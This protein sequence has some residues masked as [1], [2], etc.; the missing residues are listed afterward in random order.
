M[1]AHISFTRG[2][3]P[4]W[5]EPL[6][7]MHKLGLLPLVKNRQVH[8]GYRFNEFSPWQFERGFAS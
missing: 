1:V 6:P 5:S 7:R 4:V 3:L 8:A 2:P